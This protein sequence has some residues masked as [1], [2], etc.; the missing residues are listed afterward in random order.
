MLFTLLNVFSLTFLTHIYFFVTIGNYRLLSP[1]VFGIEFR[2]LRC[3][4]LSGSSE[5]RIL[6]QTSSIP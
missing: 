4:T 3:A 2:A 6:M 5:D 1:I